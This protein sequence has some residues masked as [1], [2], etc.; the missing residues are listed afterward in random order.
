MTKD[1]QKDVQ[2]ARERIAAIRVQQAID[3][4]KAMQE[5][6]AAEQAIRDRT[7]RLRA[8]RLARTSSRGKGRI[9]KPIRG[10]TTLEPSA[11]LR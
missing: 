5:Y 4:P 6:R 9:H 3:A 11:A 8:E 2:Q 7:D 10:G 1:L